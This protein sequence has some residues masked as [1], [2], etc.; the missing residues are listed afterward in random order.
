KAY[1]EN[2]VFRTQLYFNSSGG[3][4]QGL[5]ALMAL[6]GLGGG[7]HLADARSLPLG[8]TYNIYMVKESDYMPRLADPRIGY[9]TTDYYSLNRFMNEDKTERLIARWDIRKKNPEAEM[10]EPVAPLVWYIDD[11]V[12]E[13]WRQACADGILRWNKAFEA[14]G[15]KHA[16]EV[17][18]KPKDADWDHA[19]MRYNVLRFAQSEDAGYAIALLR[20][21]PFTGQIV[22]A[23]IT[24]DSSIVSLGGMEWKWLTQPG[25]DVAAAA[26]N[27]LV[28][29]DP[30]AQPTFRPLLGGRVSCELAPLAVENAAF[31]WTALNLLSRENVS[32]N[33]DEYIAELLRDIVSHEMGHCLGLRHNFIA[34]T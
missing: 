22:N 32:I 26:F 5:G 25:K 8:V 34:S 11:S 9:F 17:R 15:I 20:T 14:I 6:L 23:S 12:P 7:D 24:V 30:Q 16:I 2:I 10:S 29:S 4:S 19:D 27:R 33:R 31:G 18:F 28:R 1:R 3:P 13:K 21:N